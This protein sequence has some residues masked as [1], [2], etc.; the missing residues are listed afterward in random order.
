MRGGFSQS[1]NAASTHLSRRGEIKPV[2]HGGTKQYYHRLR[3]RLQASL[4]IAFIIPIAL[5]SLY[6]HYQ[7]NHNLKKVSELHLISLAESQRNTIDLF[8]QER[9][10]NIFNLSHGSD[11]K[12]EPSK[13]EMYRYIQYLRESSDSFVDIGFLNASGIQIGYAGPYPHL[14]GKDYSNELWFQTLLEQE[15]DYF[16]SDIYTG[17]RN[18]PHFTIAVRQIIDGSPL[19]MKATLDPDKLY[20]FLRTIGRGK[21]VDSS[22]VNINGVYQ[23]VDPDQGDL[24]DS[25]S[26]M[27]QM[28]DDSGAVIIK[29]PEGDPALLAYTHLNEVPWI[30]VVSQ[31]LKVAYAE[32]HRTRNIMIVA[33]S[34]LIITLFIA[35]WITTE[36]LLR[37]AQATDESRGELKTQLLHAAKL[38]AVGELAGGVAHEINNPLAIIVSQSGVI[39]DMYDPEFGIEVT[40]EDVRKELDIIDEAA[41]RAKGITRTLLDLVRKQEPQPAPCNVNQVLDSVVDGLKQKELQVSNIKLIREYDAGIPDIVVDP[42][43][44]KQVF[45]NIINNASDAIDGPGTI[46]L[47]THMNTESVKVTITDTGMG[48]TTEDMEKIFF[49][50]FTTKDVGKGTGLGLS[51][52]LTIIES[53]NG[54]IDVQSMPG[55]GSS[56]TI[57]LPITKTEESIDGKE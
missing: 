8:L 26:F 25:T 56:F 16:I 12:T 24:M 36:R 51:I 44:L 57:S 20:L 11:F 1:E 27:S 34:L 5:L 10:I 31:P 19:F 2:N 48:M 28:E 32:M 13:D 17:F 53:M 39:R 50:F 45:L 4:I 15:Q 21:G 40:P 14:H 46:T 38:V 6:F 55:A 7:Y 3:R 35:V 23:V 52:S 18:K 33:V 54:H 29:N 49:P 43:Q 47:S 9:V 30:L 22:I 42:D 41:F 37:Q